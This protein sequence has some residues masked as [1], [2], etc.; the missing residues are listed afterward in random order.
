VVAW[1]GGALLV[2]VGSFVLWVFAVLAV[3]LFWLVVDSCFIYMVVLFFCFDDFGCAPILGTS[4]R[5][6]IVFRKNT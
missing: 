1:L 4:Q 5:A 2:C 6:V 3:G